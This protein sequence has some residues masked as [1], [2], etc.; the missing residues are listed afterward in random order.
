MNKVMDADAA[1][2]ARR[3]HRLD[4]RHVRPDIKERVFEYWRNVDK[5]LGDAVA[6]LVQRPAASS[7]TVRRRPATTPTPR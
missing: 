7:R 1:R 4:A 5:A 3:D 6:E 2:P